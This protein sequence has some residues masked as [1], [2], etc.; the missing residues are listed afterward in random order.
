MLADGS[1]KNFTCGL[2]F[3]NNGVCVN[4]VVCPSGYFKLN[5]VCWPCST[6]CSSCS[7]ASLCGSC[8]NGFTFNS[9]TG[10]CECENVGK[11]RY[12][13]FCLFGV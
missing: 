12:N 3:A 5:T 10:S 4:D 8:D 11:L 13:G 9:T 7:D 6:G 1:C 2:V